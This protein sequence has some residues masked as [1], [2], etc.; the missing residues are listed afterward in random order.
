MRMRWPWMPLAVLCSTHLASTAYLPPHTSDVTRPYTP[1]LHLPLVRHSLVKRDASDLVS[2]LKSSKLAL[3]AKYGYGHGAVG[4]AIVER[5][6]SGSNLL[7]NQHT[8][9]SYFGYIAVGTPA[10]SFNVILDTGSADLW[11]A[12][13]ADAVPPGT[14][15]FD[16]SRSSSFINLNTSFA[17]SYGSGSAGGFLGSDVVQ[18]SG[19][20]VQN[21][22]FGV[23]SEITTNLLASPISGVLGLAFQS[24]ATSG[25]TPF[26]QSLVDQE[27]ALNEPVM[28]FHLTRFIN[29]SYVRSVEPGGS[30][31]LGALDHTLFTGAIDY[32]NITE[33]PSYWKLDI[34]AV[35][36]QG[37]PLD[38]SSTGRSA[39]IDTGTTL[40]GG[41]ADIIAQLYSTI[42]GSSPGTGTLT[43]YFTYPCET[44]V[45]VSISFGESENAWPVS[46]ADFKLVQLDDDTCV[47]AFFQMQTSGSGSYPSWVVGDTFLKN[48]Y[49]V[50]RASDP[51]AIG[52]AQLSDFALSQNGLNGSVP[53]P[54]NILPE[55][56][57]TA[58][59]NAASTLGLNVVL[60]ISLYSAMVVH[61]CS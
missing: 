14:P 34:A 3:E 1:G 28:A 36:V 9:S 41:P 42:P 38:L 22:V 61:L 54:T 4:G 49:S 33:S 15:L 17:I 48:V 27:G 8:D 39:A 25:A 50:F 21:Q 20:E 45:V 10:I 55:A 6:G 44:D 31:S 58:P 59:V 56:T 43:G 46:P 47:G 16:P 11:L 5:R 24:I 51:P 37:M 32:Q 26:W 18:F 30:F 29:D 19:F 23:V 35:T 12:A 2:W 60:L 13:S 7:T 53:T 40:V 52:F 57:V